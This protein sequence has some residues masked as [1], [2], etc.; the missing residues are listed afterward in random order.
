MMSVEDPI[1]VENDQHLEIMSNDCCCV[2][3]F[4]AMEVIIWKGISRLFRCFQMLIVSNTQRM[5]HQLTH[6][7]YPKI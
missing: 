4:L 1:E 6:Y 2:T 5:D 7:I 3:I